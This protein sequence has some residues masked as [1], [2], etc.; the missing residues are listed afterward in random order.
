MTPDY[1]RTQLALY[2]GIQ[3]LDQTSPQELRARVLPRIEIDLDVPETKRS[4]AM[5]QQYNNLG[6]ARR[7]KGS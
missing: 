1:V 4:V 5:H 7:D 3:V 2:A 6:L